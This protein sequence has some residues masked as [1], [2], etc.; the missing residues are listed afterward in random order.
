[1][2]QNNVFS[3][4]FLDGTIIETIYNPETEET[5]LAIYKDGKWR[6]GEK[7]TDEKGLDYYPI[8]S[9]NDLIRKEFVKLAS[10]VA[11]AVQ[12]RKLYEEVKDYIA[13]YMNI[14]DD[15]LAVSTVYVLLSWVY[16]RFNTLAYLRVIGTFGTGKS[17]FLKTMSRLCF[18]S[19]SASGVI[20]TAGIFRTND[21]IKGTLILDEADWHNSDMSSM[22]VKTLN[23]GH[24]TG[25]PAIRM[26]TSK[27]DGS[28]ITEAFVVFSPK[29]VASRERFH[30]EALESRCL[31]QFLMPIKAVKRAI[32][33]P[34]ESEAKA[35][36]LRNKLLAFRFENYH[37]ISADE[38]T[39]KDIHFPRLQQSA[40]ALTSVAA[41]VGEDI[42]EKVLAFLQ[43]YEKELQTN[44]AHDVKADVLACIL[45]LIKESLKDNVR[46][47]YMRDISEKFDKKNYEQ[48]SDI[49]SKDYI[50]NDN[51]ITYRAGTISARKIGSHVRAMG[52]NT[53]RDADGFYIALPDEQY[54]ITTL[55]ERYGI[56][57]DKVGE[58]P[59]LNDNQSEITT[60]DIKFD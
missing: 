8:S 33:F 32:D 59:K 7:Y 24:A 31:T 38:G 6:Y 3:K 45:E 37:K 44:Q 22:N 13:Q 41:A 15:F 30:D 36:E 49:K 11:P 46:K 18:K 4:V 5:Q 28:V 60:D 35:T 14:P 55:A 29:I 34:A 58:Q 26:K 53:L 20:N 50:S 52:I 2:Q 23:A 40:L 42:H 43:R 48:Y 39:L 47:I 19:M 10:A 54:K 25:S 57:V 51:V 1:M 16:E 17:R 12:N 56:E 21:F 9:S 27:S